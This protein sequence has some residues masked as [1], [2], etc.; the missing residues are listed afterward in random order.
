MAQVQKGPAAPVELVRRH[1]VPLQGHAAGDDGCQ[2]V[3]DRRLLQGGEESLVK[4]HTVLDDL[5]TAA[6]V[7]PLRKGREQ[8]RVAE[9]QG[10]LVEAARLV[11]PRG[12]VD[13]GLAAHGGIHRRQ[14]AGGH[15]AE[16][17]APLI[18][19]GGEAREIPGDAA[20]Q[21]NQNIAPAEAVPAQKVQERGVGREVFGPLPR[22]EGEG[23]RAEARRLQRRRKARPIEGGDG[24]IRRDGGGPG[25]GE[26][27]PELFPGP[28]QEAR[29]DQ[30]VVAPGG[31][32]ADA[33]HRPSTSSLRRRPSSRSRT[34]AS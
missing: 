9:H 33:C 16:G 26:D 14:E 10:G 11:F 25:A 27:R 28:V 8:R 29:L 30:N 19:G 18:G 13:A 4:E 34:R 2:L 5:G 24:L 21:G 20:P 23:D 1:G 22:R 31:G 7:L 12:E 17:H 32:D 6:P 15:L 3:P